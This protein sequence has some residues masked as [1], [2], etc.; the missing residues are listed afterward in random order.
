MMSNVRR[1]SDNRLK[2][3]PQIFRVER[4]Q[5]ASLEVVILDP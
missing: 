1:I 2:R 4:E 5:V 3:T